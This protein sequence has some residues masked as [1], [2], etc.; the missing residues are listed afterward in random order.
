MSGDSP[1]KKRFEGLIHFQDP[2]RQA[3]VCLQA[4]LGSKFATE[5][6]VSFLKDLSK[7]QEEAA[8]LLLSQEADS[9]SSLSQ[10]ND[11]KVQ[12]ML[13]HI[14]QLKSP[15][16]L[17]GIN[18][19]DP[20]S[21]KLNAWIDSSDLLA[22][23]SLMRILGLAC[24]ADANFDLADSFAWGSVRK[25]KPDAQGQEEFFREGLR[26]FFFCRT[27]LELFQN[28]VQRSMP[29]FKKIQNM[30]I[31]SDGLSVSL[32]LDGAPAGSW[33]ELGPNAFKQYA[34]DDSPF[35]AVN[36]RSAEQLQCMIVTPLRLPLKSSERIF[37]KGIVLCREMKL[38]KGSQRTKKAS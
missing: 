24:R 12:H 20:H 26:S 6:Q 30:S 3:F 16:P 15:K 38:E 19:F 1:K 18:W 9:L 37:F 23:S 21:A 2:L 35:T 27:R 8:Y 14:R 13:C 4:S 22:S 25:V 29:V 10:L 31:V 34:Q 36:Y 17:D 5:G 33:K 7:S 32:L 28:F 11:L